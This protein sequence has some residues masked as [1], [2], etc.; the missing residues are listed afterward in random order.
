MI[1]S[2]IT[3][4]VLAIIFALLTQYWAT[5]YDHQ[6]ARAGMGYRMVGPIPAS[7]H[8][9]ETAYFIFVGWVLRIILPLVGIP[10]WL[11]FVIVVIFTAGLYSQQT[12]L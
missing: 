2:L 4:V 7:H 9:A 3:A 1:I 5:H 6:R 12:S 8:I 10:Y 11:V